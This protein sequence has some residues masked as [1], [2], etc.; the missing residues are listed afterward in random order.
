[1]NRP[2]C[3]TRRAGDLLAEGLVAHIGAHTVMHTPAPRPA[4]SRAGYPQDH[5]ANDVDPVSRN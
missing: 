2:V 4:A 5:R 3:I 1:M